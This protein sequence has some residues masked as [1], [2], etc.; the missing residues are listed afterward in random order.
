M[1]SYQR[2]V[3]LNE[4]DAL[5]YYTQRANTRRS[6]SQVLFVDLTLKQIIRNMS[7]TFV[8]ILNELVSGQVQTKEQLVMTFFKGDRMVYI[9]T[10]LVLVALV[11]Y[12]SDI[13]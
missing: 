9:G 11:I 4:Q 2:A 7:Q 5:T 6:D 8:E 1:V 13:L 3:E 12:V 10:L